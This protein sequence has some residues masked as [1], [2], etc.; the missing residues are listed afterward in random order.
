VRTAY[1]GDE[2]S[3]SFAACKEFFCGETAGYRTVREVAA[4][5][6][7]GECDECVLPAEN[8]VEGAVTATEDVLVDFDLYIRSRIVLPIRHCL[9]ALPGAKLL[10]IEKVYSH[11]QALAQCGKWLSEN[12]PN[13]ERIPTLS[14]SYA[15]GLIENARQAAV[16]GSAKNGQ[17]IIARGIEDY[18]HNST[19]FIRLSKELNDAGRRASVV[20]GAENRPGGLLYVLKLF[21]SARM[22]MTRIESR[23]SKAGLG[24]YIF[25]VDFVLPESNGDAALKELLCSLRKNAASVKFLGR[26]DDINKAEA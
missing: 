11:P 15:L 18:K 1:L 9:V 2:Y 24:D 8:S 7:S 3:H 10:D 5:V 26:Y 22:N 25:F 19:R 21:E 20:F 23:P 12:V 4:A 6:V 17:E 16:A 14:T 13:A